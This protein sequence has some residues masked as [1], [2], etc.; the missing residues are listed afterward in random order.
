MWHHHLPKTVTAGF[1]VLEQWTLTVSLES[2]SVG[3]WNLRGPTPRMATRVSL[4]T[5]AH[6]F[7][8]SL[9]DRDNGQ[10]WWF[11]WSF[12]IKALFPPGWQP[13]G[14]GPL[15]FPWFFG[16]FTPSK[17]M[18]LWWSMGEPENH[19]LVWYEIGF[20]SSDGWIFHFWDQSTSWTKKHWN[21]NP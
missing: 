3:A 11:S 9:R 17:S 14:V 2:W 19:P 15:E 7:R 10:E 12:K 16:L 1:P 18:N 8:L 6:N 4:E 20:V 21:Q 5:L 13:G